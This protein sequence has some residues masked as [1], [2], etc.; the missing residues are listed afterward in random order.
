MGSCPQLPSSSQDWGGKGGS[1]GGP[2]SA[3][4]MLSASST[5]PP[6]AA[7]A[8]VGRSSNPKR[9]KSR[10][11]VGPAH[12]TCGI[13]PLAL[14]CVLVEASN[15]GPFSLLCFQPYAVRGSSRPG[16]V[17]VR[18]PPP[19]TAAPRRHAI[20]TKDRHRVPSVVSSPTAPL[21]V[22]ALRPAS[23]GGCWGASLRQAPAR[24]SDD[25]GGWG[26]SSHRT[27]WGGLG[28]GGAAG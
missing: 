27:P 1:Q 28:G 9:A 26:G 25:G 3:Q 7:P 6:A 15:G 12:A 2:A 22:V 8:L 24:Q 13:L 14:A 11:P 16:T 4:A 5:R 23:R 21:L 19:P 18:E 20:N 17:P 10:R